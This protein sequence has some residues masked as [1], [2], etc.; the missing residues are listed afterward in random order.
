MMKEK[1]LVTRSG[2][3]RWVWSADTAIAVL[4]G[5][6]GSFDAIGEVGGTT[7]IRIHGTVYEADG[8]RGGEDYSAPF[9]LVLLDKLSEGLD[10]EIEIGRGGKCRDN[11]RRAAGGF[12]RFYVNAGK[13]G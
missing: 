13:N 10:V 11:E 5:G 3:F 1:Y 12:V 8:G 2:T 9:R 7:R 6:D 4:R